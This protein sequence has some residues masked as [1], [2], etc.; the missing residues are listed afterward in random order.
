DST[1]RW[2]MF[3]SEAFRLNSFILEVTPHEVAHQWWGHLVGWSS[4]HDQWLS[5]GFADF[6]ASL[7]LQATRKTNADYL[8]FWERQRN[9]LLTKNRFGRTANEAGPL[10]LGLRLST[11]KNPGGYNRVI[12]SKGAYVVHMLRQMM[13][14]PNIKDQSFIATMKDFV[15]SFENNN[16]T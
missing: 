1:Q 4:Y 2:K 7:F 10:W 5:E 13:W 6:S 15:K 14:D 3:D 11:Q 16:A 12:Y 8:K 9:S